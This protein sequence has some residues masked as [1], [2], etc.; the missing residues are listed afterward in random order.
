MK[1]IHA[2]PALMI[3][4]L[5]GAA[6][7]RAMDKMMKPMSE[8]EKIKLAESAGPVEITKNAT[9]MDMDMTD[10]A[11]PKP[12]QLRAGTNGWACF[13]MMGEPMCLDKEWQK[14]AEAWMSHTDPKIEGTGI[15]YMLAGDKG[16][17]NTDP[18]ATAATADNKWVVSPPHIMVLYKDLAMLDAYPTDPMS[19]GPW[20]M[21]KGTPY[22]H[23]MVPVS[24]KEA[25]KMP[26]K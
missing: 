16:A 19:G 13:A 11:K 20:V 8:A 22:A 14:W 9:I 18:F 25:A 4:A 15:A 2:I 21:W 10:P 12:V 26:S 5:M 17:S 3:A 23:V 6:P 7:S 24:M 1:H